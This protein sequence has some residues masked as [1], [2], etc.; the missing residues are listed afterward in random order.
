M[1]WIM[2]GAGKPAAAGAGG[3]AAGKTAA[4]GGGG[5]ASMHSGAPAS[6]DVGDVKVAKA[7]GP[8]ARTVAEIVEKLIADAGANQRRERT[9]KD[10]RQRLSM[11]AKTY[12]ERRIAEITREELKD[13][14]HNPTLAA[15][16]RINYAV[17]LSQLWNYAIAN[18][19]AEHNIPA[20]NA[21]P[22]R[23]DLTPPARP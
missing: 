9:I 4:A 13:W 17:K 16:S 3:A 8:Q 6:A 20:S 10:L 14:L 21:R 7:S 18:G 2:G 11:F 22:P 5:V 23:P 12:G 19:W 1:R 15:R